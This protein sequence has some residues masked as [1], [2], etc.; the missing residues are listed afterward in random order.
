MKHTQT[1]SR[2]R[3]PEAAI[4][5]LEKQAMTDLIQRNVSQV[6]VLVNVLAGLKPPPE[7]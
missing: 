4:S 5:L 3:T 2:Q 7:S 1:I 6:L